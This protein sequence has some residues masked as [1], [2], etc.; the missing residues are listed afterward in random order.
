V[1]R[2]AE[3]EVCVQIHEHLLE[4]GLPVKE[5]LA[6]PTIMAP[7]TVKVGALMSAR[8]RGPEKRFPTNAEGTS[9]VHNGLFVLLQDED[10][11]LDVE[12]IL[13]AAKTRDLELS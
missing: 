5:V 2:V 9:P 1:S 3:M 11:A 8:G 13:Y 7:E 10:G 12:Q 6:V 4:H